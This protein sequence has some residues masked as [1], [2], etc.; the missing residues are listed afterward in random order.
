MSSVSLQSVHKSF[1]QF[2]K[3]TCDKDFN[4]LGSSGDIQGSARIVIDNKIL[5]GTVSASES[6]VSLLFN[7]TVENIS[8]SVM[9]SY[10]LN[11][12]DELIGILSDDFDFECTSRNSEEQQL[13]SNKSWV[14]ARY[15]S[16]D[17]EGS[18]MIALVAHYFSTSDEYR[19]HVVIRFGEFAAGERQINQQ[20]FWFEIDD[21]GQLSLKTLFYYDGE[22]DTKFM[23]QQSLTNHGQTLN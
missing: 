22:S 16:D 11:S 4:L 6:K 23:C 14:L 20:D 9:N 12:D 1:E 18:R 17:G 2:L 3:T 19:E 15:E 10:R 8:A 21:A 5:L 7:N 13:L